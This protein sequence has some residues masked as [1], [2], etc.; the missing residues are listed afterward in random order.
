MALDASLI[1]T[2]SAWSAD[3]IEAFLDGAAIPLRL[4]CLARGGAPLVCSLW[5][6]RDGD[7]LWCATQRSA[8]VVQL[9]AR[10]PRC[11]FEVAGDSPP[12]RGVRGQGVARLSTSDGPAVL[13]RL[14]DRY[15]GSRNT[16]FARWLLDRSADEVAIRVEPD[17]LT[18]WDFTRRMAD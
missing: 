12:Y 4:A 17:W 7:T 15:L 13:A 6:L 3:E 8:R 18:S 2:G 5:F 16:N 11:G 14:I 9:L 1:R 10:D